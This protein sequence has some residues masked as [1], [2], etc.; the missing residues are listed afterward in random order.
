M[1]QTNSKEVKSIFAFTEKVIDACGPRIT[2]D[3]S[4]HKA[5]GMIREELETYCDSVATE[6]FSVH[7]NSFLGWIRLLVV[8]YVISTVSL[9]L[10]WP[11]IAAFCMIFSVLTM[12]LEFFLYKEF[13]DPFWKKKIGKNVIGI[14]EPTGEA[15]HQVIV[16][17]HHDSAYVFN[18]LYYQPKLYPI[19]LYGSLGSVAYVLIL[20]LVWWIIQLLPQASL[21]SGVILFLQISTSTLLLLVLQMWFFRGSKGTP[22]AGDNMVSVAIANQIGKKFANERLK[23]TRVIIASWD[24]EEA[25][26]RGARAYCKEHREAL[27]ATP[28]FNFNMDC[29]FTLKELFFLNTDVNGSVQLSKEMADECV[30]IAKS[31]GHEADAKPIA[32]LT[33]GTDAGEFGRIGVDATCLIAMPWGNSD[34]EAVYHTPND[35][36]DA[37]EPAAVEAA[38][39]IVSTFIQN[40]DK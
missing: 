14:I 21:G 2:G 8:M 17:G 23:H 18:F 37:I 26:L 31:L 30:S 5:A 33:G 22:G 27:L 36:I 13:I 4:T 16:S 6:S 9:W 32:F 39:Q 11:G 25:G 3:P 40:K 29:P 15:K 10:Q 28:T 35:T 38:F 1:S 12:T 24:S 20:S 7:P 19:R 34:H